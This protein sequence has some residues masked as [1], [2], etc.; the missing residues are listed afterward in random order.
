M[1]ENRPM[2][3]LRYL[4]VVVV[5]L[6]VLAPFVWIL[7]N[8]LRPVAEILGFPSLLPK[9]WTLEN[10]NRMWW[11]TNFV[12]WTTN[13][14]LIAAGTVIISVPL[15]TAAAYS[16]YR[17]RYRGRAMLSLLLLGV[18]AFPTITLVVPLFSLFSQ[19][20]LV[21]SLAGLAIIDSVLVLP[22]AI[23]LLQAFLKAVPREIE[24][25]AALDGIGRVE[26]LVR[27]VLPQIAPGVFAV[28]LFALIISWT[29]YMFASVF[30]TSD[31]NQTLALGLSYLMSQYTIDW[32]TTTAAAVATGA[33]IVLLFAVAGRWFLRGVSTGAVK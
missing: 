28:M 7:L 13:S 14:A 17:T 2:A 9:Q 15:A 18:Y 26:T 33:P 31:N 16:I 8:A 10:F 6:A 22:F 5:V 25:A 21:D 30:I 3:A 29:E 27:I 1:T 11:Y 19:V 12:Q 20:G 4:G 24:E 23:W 32:G